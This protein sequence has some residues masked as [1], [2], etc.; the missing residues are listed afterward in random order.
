MGLSL[1]EMGAG[2]GRENQTHLGR[3]EAG[4]GWVEGNLRPPMGWDA[5]CSLQKPLLCILQP[6]AAGPQEKWTAEPG[7]Q[8]LLKA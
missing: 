2:V 8:W 6:Q 5:G 3:W 1:W 4:Q 7:C